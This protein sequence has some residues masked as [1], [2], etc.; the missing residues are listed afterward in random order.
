MWGAW[1]PDAPTS[2]QAKAGF[3]QLVLE[4]WGKGTP[5]R[6]QHRWGHRL[7]RWSPGFLA[8]SRGHS[9]VGRQ[10]GWEG[11][12]HCAR[13]ASSG[14]ERTDV[15]KLPPKNILLRLKTC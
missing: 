9:G 15:A 13:E 5:T 6:E 1:G 14:S 3:F 8:V 11:P 12:D 7:S 4:K 2:P 10:E